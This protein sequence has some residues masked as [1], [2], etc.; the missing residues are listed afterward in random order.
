MV[1]VA[2]ERDYLI[3]LWH[4]EQMK[5][6]RL[7]NVTGVTKLFIAGLRIGCSKSEFGIVFVAGRFQHLH[8]RRHCF[9]RFLFLWLSAEH[10]RCAVASQTP[11]VALLWLS[12][13]P[14]LHLQHMI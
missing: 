5:V 6:S 7:W 13:K 8:D 10:S 14:F 3:T 2:L 1:Q 11:Q 4:S 12:R 9:R